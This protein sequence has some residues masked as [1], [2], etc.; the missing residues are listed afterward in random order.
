MKS[1]GEITP[2]NLDQNIQKLR[3]EF[4]KKSYYSENHPKTSHEYKRSMVN[5][6]ITRT[7]KALSA[8]KIKWNNLNKLSDKEML[9]FYRKHPG[10]LYYKEIMSNMKIKTFNN[11]LK[12]RAYTGKDFINKKIR[13]EHNNNFGYKKFGNSIYN[14][15]HGNKYNNNYNS[16]NRN[17]KF[18]KISKTNYFNNQGKQQKW[19]TNYVKNY[20]YNFNYN[21]ASKINKMKKIQQGPNPVNTYIINTLNVSE[22]DFINSGLNN[23]NPE[24]VYDNSRKDLQNEINKLIKEKEENKNLIKKQKKL[25]EKFEED[26]DN[27]ENRINSIIHENKK[28]KAKIETYMENQ[29]QLIMLIK[30]VQKSGVDVEALIDKWNNEVEN[31]HEENEVSEY[32]E[33]ISDEINE[34]NSKIDPSSFIPINIEE[35]HVNKK[36]FKGI[37]KLNF[38]NINNKENKKTKFKNNSK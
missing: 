18:P 30:I 25:I 7:N 13:M 17:E 32:K 35:P 11:P 19:K 29:E 26:N 2:D 1:V 5:K 34:L 23:A 14:Y 4:N 36:V 24:K 31:M 20:N 21:N 33:S 15:N 12:K 27:L 28:I 37:P 10:Y 8:N 9:E 16:I 3:E 6:R 22:K 38:S